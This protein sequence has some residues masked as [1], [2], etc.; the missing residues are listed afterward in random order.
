[1]V[2]TEKLDTV[3]QLIRLAA[4]TESTVPFSALYGCFAKNT[5]RSDMH[6][7]LEEA[8]NQLAHWNDAIYS[9][10]M[11]KKDTGCPGSG[12]FDTFS[13]HRNAEYEAIAPN[14]RHVTRLTDLQQQAITQLERARVYQHAALNA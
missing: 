3:V 7:T 12:F 8:C 6:D 9:A 14:I 5:P 1:M 10:V 2:I 11:A 13:I 4:Q